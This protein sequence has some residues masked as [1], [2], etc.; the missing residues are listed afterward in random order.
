MC[1]LGK[2]HGIIWGVVLG[3]DTVIDD[4]SV[5]NDDDIK[6]D[7]DMVEE[8]SESSGVKSPPTPPNLSDLYTD[9][10]LLTTSNR[11]RSLL[12][13]LRF[14]PFRPPGEPTNPEDYGDVHGARL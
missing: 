8:S 1:N 14:L 13:I 6:G 10:P 5:T 2:D 11:I 9:K 7:D 12:H 4:V 3:G